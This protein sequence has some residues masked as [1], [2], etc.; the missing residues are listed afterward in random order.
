MKIDQEEQLDLDEIDVQILALLQEHCKM[1]LA[2]IGQRV[3]LSAP[4]VIER[5]KKLE[6]GGVI[7][8]YTALLDTRKLGCDVTA[9]IGVLTS[10]PGGIRDVEQQIESRPEVLECHHVTG[11]YTL[12]LKVKTANTTTLEEL[13]SHLRSIEG[14]SRTE[15]MVVL[16]THTER[17]LRL[18]PE[19]PLRRRTRRGV[20]TLL[21]RGESAS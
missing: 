9:F 10:H 5:I 20:A 2:K 8:G 19:V 3:G 17:Q 13:I 16:S 11:G 6:E 7:T 4:A 14:V 12:L 15:T 1:P 21:L 18:R